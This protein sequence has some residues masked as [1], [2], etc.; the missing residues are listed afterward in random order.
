MQNRCRCRHLRAIL[1]NLSMLLESSEHADVTLLCGSERIKAHSVIL[2]AR[3]PVF[4]AQLK[5]SLACCSLDAVPVPE[6]ITAETLRR[7][8]RFIYT[9]HLLPS[10]AE[11]AQHLLNAADVYDLPRL[12]AIAEQKLTS[13]LSV[14]NAACTLALAEQHRCLGLK[15]AAL[16]FIKTNPAVLHSEGWAHL[17]ASMPSIVEDLLLVFAPVS[18]ADA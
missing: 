18:V 8:L 6:E 12:R 17:K 13:A 4:K 5:G 1:D 3:S 11:E 16:A 7:T 2:C 9:D 14:E 15:S 10:S